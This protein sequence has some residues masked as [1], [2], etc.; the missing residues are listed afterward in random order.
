MRFVVKWHGEDTI[1]NVISFETETPEE[2]VARLEKMFALRVL[3]NTHD[4]Y[5]E[6]NVTLYEVIPRTVRSWWVT[7]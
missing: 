3:E 4:V 1:L 5:G 2:A 6:I 7:P